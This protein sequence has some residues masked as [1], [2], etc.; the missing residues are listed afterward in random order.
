[1]GKNRLSY[2]TA[3]DKNSKIL[4]IMILQPNNGP[5]N[6]ISVTEYGAHKQTKCRDWSNKQV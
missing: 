3:G 4:L 5:Y 1:M 6:R 2:L